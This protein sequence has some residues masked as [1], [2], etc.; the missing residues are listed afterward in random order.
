M[1]KQVLQGLSK[2]QLVF[3]VLLETPGFPRYIP[4]CLVEGRNDILKIRVFGVGCVFC[5]HSLSSWNIP[6]VKIEASG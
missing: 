1:P 2:Y 6:E 5:S 3:S 4:P